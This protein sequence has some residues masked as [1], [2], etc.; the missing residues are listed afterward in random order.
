MLFGVKTGDKYNEQLIDFLVDEH[1]FTRERANSLIN[2]IAIYILNVLVFKKTINTPFG[3]MVLGP[4]GVSITEPNLALIELL[5][6][7]FSDDKLAHMIE[8]IIKGN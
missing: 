5:K 7:D 4:E 2:S 8:N 3:V 6:E 1:N